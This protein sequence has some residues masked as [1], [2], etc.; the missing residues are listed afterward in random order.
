MVK[1][2]RAVRTRQAL[3]RA[4]AEVF[5]HNGYA[6]ASLPA[7]SKR[8][9][10]S[11]GALHFHFPSKDALADEVEDAATRAVQ[12]LAGRCRR[13]SGSALA[14][15]VAATH[16]LAAALTADP[17][18]WAGFRLGAD[19]ARRNRAGLLEWWH[20]WVL[21]VVGQA[22]EAGEL[23]DGVCPEGA[24]VAVVAATVGFEALGSRDRDWL[25]EE[26]MVQFWTFLLPSLAAPPARSL[27][28]VL[29][30]ARTAS[31]ARRD[32]SADLVAA[33]GTDPAT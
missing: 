22:R 5:A 27:T 28:Q 29:E 10:V 16:H 25:S 1:Q 26:R 32:G 30:A 11:A 13:T 21:D 3:L 6:R 18:T 12:E 9:G 19:P 33:A 14:A 15:L 31:P 4:A 17:V 2:V 7:I 23:A 8:A 24:A 20:A